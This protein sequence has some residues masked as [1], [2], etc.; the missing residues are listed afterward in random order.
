MLP[1][2]ACGWC[3]RYKPRSHCQTQ[4]CWS[5]YP[6]CVFASVF[7]TDSLQGAQMLGLGVVAC[8]VMSVCVCVWLMFIC[9]HD[10]SS[11]C[12]DRVETCLLQWSFADCNI[13]TYCKPD[14]SACTAT[15][16]DPRKGVKHTCR[17]TVQ[18]TPD[19]A[20]VVHISCDNESASRPCLTCAKWHGVQQPTAM[21]SR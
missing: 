1:M 17:C 20:I 8:G 21:C 7:G 18:V 19:T 9:Q 3:T 5:S 16:H 12:E 11:A 6:A 4:V 2:P 15:A 14:V 13:S 10:T